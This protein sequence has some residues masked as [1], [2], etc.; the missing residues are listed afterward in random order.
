[1]PAMR[2]RTTT[3]RTAL[4]RQ[5]PFSRSLVRGLAGKA[6]STVA[7]L[8]HSMQY[9]SAPESAQS[10]NAWLDSHQRQFGFF[11]DNVW[12]KP[13]DR[14]SA[15]STQP[16][17]GALM[18]QSLQA[19]AED[20]DSAVAAAQRAQPQWW[21]LSPHARSRHIYSLARHLQK[22]SRLL[23]TVESLDNGKTIRE[24]RDADIPL[25]IRHFYSHAGWAQVRPP[26]FSSRKTITMA[27]SRG[28]GS[29]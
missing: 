27:R 2:L 4:P 28:T 16:S 21:G 8:F 15:S 20:V 25:A 24:T 23:A 3:R 6:T 19:T 11:I 13:E 7:E 26:T 5:L 1:M 22:H 12:V 18:A 9:T 14:A 10:A 17:N 29:Y